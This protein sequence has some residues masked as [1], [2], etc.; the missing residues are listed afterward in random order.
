MDEICVICRDSVD[1][2]IKIDDCRCNIYYCSS[3]YTKI[4]CCVVCRRGD[5]SVNTWWDATEIFHNY[6]LQDSYQYLRTTYPE[7]KS[8][9]IIIDAICMTLMWCIAILCLPMYMILNCPYI[10]YQR[11]SLDIIYN[12]I[13][14][15][16]VFIYCMFASLVCGILS[17]FCFY[18]IKHRNNE[19]L[20]HCILWLAP[21]II[22]I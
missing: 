9:H 17:V 16:L 15:G 1:K 8:S 2:L 3:S 4:N 6:S 5:L 12:A 20:K 14:C 22:T 11:D 13:L 7:M 19:Y 21:L 10:V 18:L